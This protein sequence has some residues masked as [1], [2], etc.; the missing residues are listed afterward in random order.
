M[1]RRIGN[2]F[3]K[4]AS[5]ENLNLAA[6]KAMRG[7][8][9]TGETCRFFFHLEREL[10]TLQAELE[11]E[12]YQP[13]QYRYFTVHD[14]KERQI[15]VAPFRDRVVHHAIVNV[16]D[17]IYERVFIHDSYA[18]RK[19]KGT[20]KAIIQAQSFLR[21]WGG[22]YKADV[23]QYFANVHHG[24][25][26]AILE[27]KI[28][29]G[30]LLDLLER[31]VLNIDA[32]KGLPIGNLPSQF[33]ANV[34]LDPFDHFLKDRLG[35]KGYIRY[36]DDFVI[37]DDDPHALDSLMREAAGYLAEELHLSLRPKC[38][39]RNRAVHGLS[40]LGMRIHRSMLRVRP[41]NRRRSLRRVHRRIAEWRHGRIGEELLVASLVSI[42][43]HLHHFCPSL[44]M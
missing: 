26:M 41:E 36:M 29:D 8:G 19:N 22:Y 10:C 16:L 42:E 12:S 33:L 28:K 21:R 20:H 17:P 27:R 38:T 6:G 1:P 5:F 35:V 13:G 37:F 14:P 30:R 25:L 4:V 44:S 23:R 18:T 11:S 43:G 32:D 15:A 2:L 40:F 24:V 9:R 39:Y 31:I 3:G 7:C 34:Y